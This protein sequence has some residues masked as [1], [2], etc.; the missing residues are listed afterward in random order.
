MHKHYTV[1]NIIQEAREQECERESERNGE[2]EARTQVLKLILFN[3][4]DFSNNEKNR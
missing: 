4:Q 2:G 3:F 1:Y